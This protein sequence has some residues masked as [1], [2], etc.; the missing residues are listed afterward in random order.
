VDLCPLMHCQHFCNRDDSR[1]VGDNYVYIQNTK[2]N[3]MYS[4]NYVDVCLRMWGRSKI[5]A[6]YKMELTSSNTCK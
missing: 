1:A 4:Q 6:V 3:S 2:Q 5:L